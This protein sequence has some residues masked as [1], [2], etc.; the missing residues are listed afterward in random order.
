VELN[1]VAQVFDPG[2]GEGGGIII[3]NA[4]HADHAVLGLHFDAQLMQQIFILAQKFGD[5]SEREH[6]R[7]RRHAQAA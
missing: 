1:E 5:P 3:A 7:N 2:L 4:M 6:M